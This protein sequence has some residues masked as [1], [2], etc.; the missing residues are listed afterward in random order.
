MEKNMNVTLYP[1]CSLD[2]SKIITT[3]YCESHTDERNLLTLTSIVIVKELR[4]EE[5]Y[6]LYR[7]V[8]SFSFSNAYDDERVY[9]LYE[10]ETLIDQIWVTEKDKPFL[11]PINKSL[12]SIKKSKKFKQIVEAVINY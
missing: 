3:M 12:D 11:F 9:E 1:A 8:K 6:Y 7:I 4:E 5:Y 10:E 2:F